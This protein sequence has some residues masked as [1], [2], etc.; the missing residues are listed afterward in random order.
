[1]G[2]LPI[3]P[4]KSL[5][6]GIGA[7]AVKLG[8]VAEGGGDDVCGVEGQDLGG[9]DFVSFHPFILL[10]WFHGMLSHFPHI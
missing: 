2:F 1:M 8:Q 5:D 4:F 6:G 7:L 3:L 9:R 10:I